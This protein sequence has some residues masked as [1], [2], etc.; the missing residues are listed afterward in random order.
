MKLATTSPPGGQ[1]EFL[2]ELGHMA[3]VAD[4]IGMDAL[5]HFR[6]QHF[7]FGRPARSRHARLGVDDD[8]VGI[9]GLALS[10]GMSA[11]SAQLV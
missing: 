6:K 3:M 9:D 5:G 7:L 11:S 8:L 1:G 2:I 4:A 10:S